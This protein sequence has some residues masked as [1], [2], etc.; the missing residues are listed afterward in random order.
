M[1]IENLSNTQIL[2]IEVNICKNKILVAGIYKPS[3][4]TEASFNT[5]PETIISKLS[6]TYEKLI[7]KGYFHLTMSNPIL[8]QFSNTFSLS[9][10]NIDPTCFKNSKNPRS[11]KHLRKNF[12]PSF[13]KTNVFETGISD[14]Y[15]IIPTIMK[16][17]ITRESLKT[18][19][20]RDCR[21]VLNFLAN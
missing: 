19:Y 14:H 11:I 12:K 6:N 18:K 3:N 2:T 9:P 20:Y 21:L 15:K 8:S 10:L 13:M 16:L 5:N 1:K 7:L 17:H 4:L